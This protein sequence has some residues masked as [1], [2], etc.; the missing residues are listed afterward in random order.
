[1]T[2]AVPSTNFP[3]APDANYPA[4]AAP[5]SGQPTKVDPVDDKFTPG[6]SLPATY[7]NKLLAE[8][9]ATIAAL[10]AAANPTPKVVNFGNLVQ[11]S[12]GHTWPADA[13]FVVADQLGIT[14]LGGTATPFLTGVAAGDVFQF[15]FT[16]GL[17]L[18][19]TDTAS[20]YSIRLK[21]SET[22]TDFVTGTWADVGSAA[23]TQR[24]FTGGNGGEQY[25]TASWSS[26]YV[27]AG[28]TGH[29][30]FALSMF[31]GSDPSA[32]AEAIGGSGGRYTWYRAN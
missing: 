17:Y 25:V 28:T 30:R 14:D 21:A 12:G 23:H 13:S 2:I 7:L 20:G 9:D 6:V 1:M 27:A 8:R 4:G 10:V 16:I 5:W 15:D 31:T 26:F 18:P 22:A 24:A 29:L 19:S 32:T 3:W 11:K